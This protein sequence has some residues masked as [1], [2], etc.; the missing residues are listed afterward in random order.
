MKTEA[1]KT[2]KR[3]A[4]PVAEPCLPASAQYPRPANRRNAM[5]LVPTVLSPVPVTEP[6]TVFCMS[7]RP[8][9]NR[10]GEGFYIIVRGKRV[11]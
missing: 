11:K 8:E 3:I 1:P 6:A 7:I 10:D 5:G 2:R 9:R 4:L